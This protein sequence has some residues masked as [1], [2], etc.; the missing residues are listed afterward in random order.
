MNTDKEMVQIESI[1]GVYAFVT[2]TSRVEK[3][4]VILGSR[5]V[6][7]FPDGHEEVS[8]RDHCSIMVV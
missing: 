5:K 2:Q 7:I 1:L 4:R 3:D 6:T 8:E